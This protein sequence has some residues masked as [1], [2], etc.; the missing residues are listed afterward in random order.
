MESLYGAGT[1][2]VP[3]MMLA[4][5]LGT[6]ALIGFTVWIVAGRM[7]LR[8]LLTAVQPPAR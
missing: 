5:G 3:Y 7:R 2:P 6:A 8:R 1:D 4:Y